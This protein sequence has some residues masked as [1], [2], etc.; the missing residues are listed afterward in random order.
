MLEAT[1]R[2]KVAIVS[3]SSVEQQKTLAG[4]IVLK[5]LSPSVFTAGELKPS[6]FFFCTAPPPTP[7]L[8]NRDHGSVLASID[9]SSTA[10]FVFSYLFLLL[11]LSHLRI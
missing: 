7:V 1:G 8:G 4:K 11:P 5:E 10:S 6:T 9:L 2:E 3:C